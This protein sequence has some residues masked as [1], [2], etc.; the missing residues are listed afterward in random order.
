MS[1]GDGRGLH[2]GANGWGAGKL[3]GESDAGR[4]NNRDRDAIGMNKVPRTLKASAAFLKIK[5]LFREAMC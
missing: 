5:G 1:R 2:R 3:D 4:D